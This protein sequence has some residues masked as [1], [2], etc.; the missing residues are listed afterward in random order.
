MLPAGLAIAGVLVAVAA[1]A[2]GRRAPPPEGVSVL[3]YGR[4]VRAA[5]A[6]ALGLPFLAAALAAWRMPLDE[7]PVRFWILVSGAALAFLLF[8][9]VR[10]EVQG[11]R[12]RVTADALEGGSPWRRPVH[13]PWGEVR[14]VR[15]NAASQ[16]FE[17]EGGG[18]ATVRVSAWLE[19]LPALAR[20][21]EARG[22]LSGE[23]AGP[24]A[25]ERLGSL[26]GGG[27]AKAA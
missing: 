13:I 10:I 27:D 4:V 11:V 2:T 22:L 23:A 24:G 21:L 16:W 9:L 18:G 5:A 25:R 19:G 20:A 8:W 12:H 6:V 7:E 1:L 17:I 3:A 14:A 15:W 26:A